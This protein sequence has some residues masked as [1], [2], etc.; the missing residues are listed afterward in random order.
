MPLSNGFGKWP[1]EYGVGV[2][3]ERLEDPRCGI[4]IQKKCFSCE[5]QTQVKSSIFQHQPYLNPSER[6]TIADKDGTVANYIKQNNLTQ[7]EYEE[8]LNN[9]NKNNSK[10][11]Y[12]FI[13]PK[14]QAQNNPYTKNGGKDSNKNTPRGKENSNFSK[15][16]SQNKQ[17]NAPTKNPQLQN[18]PQRNENVD[19]TANNKNQIVSNRAPTMANT[20]K[21]TKVAGKKEGGC[22]IL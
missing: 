5:H 12:K 20:N 11:D 10:P 9:Y 4:C 18:S 14:K 15:Q 13:D 6:Y 1:Q 22:T 21:N 16:S 7:E 3:P 8:V 19:I 2:Q 17:N